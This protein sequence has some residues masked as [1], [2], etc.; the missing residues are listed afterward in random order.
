MKVLCYKVLFHYDVCG[1]RTEAE[2]NAER[3]EKNK[4]IQMNAAL[5]SAES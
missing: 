3:I 2:A 4:A 5:A 1:I